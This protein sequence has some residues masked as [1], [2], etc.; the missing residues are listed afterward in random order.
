MPHRQPTILWSLLGS[1]NCP[2]DQLK[3]LHIPFIEIT[4]LDHQVTLRNIQVAQSVVVT[5]TN[6]VPALKPYANALASLPIVAVGPATARALGQLGCENV[7]VPQRHD[8]QGVINLL[9]AAPPEQ[10]VLFPRGNLGGATLLKYFQ[11]A[12]IRH[13]SL[14]VYETRPRGIGDLRQQLEQVGHPDFIVLGSPSAVAVWQELAVAI[15]PAPRIAA[16]GPVTALACKR[17]GLDVELTGNGDADLLVGDLM[18]RYGA[19]A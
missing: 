14:M 2:S 10:P 4:H 1:P 3:W 17:A 13:F 11:S 6:A 8:T 15:S 19:V 5:S 16:I 7:S 9:E 12:A 18:A